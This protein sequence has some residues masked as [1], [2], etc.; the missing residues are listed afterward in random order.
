LR[1]V[2]SDEAQE[3]VAETFL[4]A[5]RRLDDVPTEP[6][7]WLFNVAGKVIANQRRGARRRQAF[8]NRRR[9][10]E[11]SRWVEVDPADEVATRFSVLQAL[12]RLPAAE[13]EALTLTVWEGL[14][15]REGATAAGCSRATFSVRLHRARKRLMKELG[16]TGHSFGEAPT[17]GHLEIGEAK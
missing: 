11:P 8:L 16:G 12:D 10:L 2:T 15:I 3:I 17:V 5:W 9:A 14:D 13:R 1:R 4:V 7:P 6:L